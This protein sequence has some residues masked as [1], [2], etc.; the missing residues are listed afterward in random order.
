MNMTKGL[1]C[2]LLKPLHCTVFLPNV[3]FFRQTLKSV[4]SGQFIVNRCPDAL[5]GKCP[6]L[7][8]T[9]ESKQ[10]GRFCVAYEP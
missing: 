8:S 7:I 6:A 9:D 4:D 5:G 10:H 2:G 1:D 3:R